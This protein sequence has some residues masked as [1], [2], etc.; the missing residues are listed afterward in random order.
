MRTR[1]K[2][3]T[4]LCAVVMTFGVCLSAYADVV[5]YENGSQGIVVGTKSESGTFQVANSMFTLGNTSGA[6]VTVTLPNG[7]TLIINNGDAKGIG[8]KNPTGTCTYSYDKKKHTLVITEGAAAAT[9][10][11]KNANAK[12][13]KPSGKSPAKASDVALVAQYAV[14]LGWQIGTSNNGDMALLSPTAVNA[15][16]IEFP[17]AGSKGGW[18]NGTSYYVNEAFSDI[19]LDASIDSLVKFID[20]HTK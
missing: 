17:S 6:A 2:V 18:A 8:T 5:T 11:A 3:L 19:E 13:Q 10:P 9:T 20:K 12:I 16:M 4:V 7:S 15:V 1:K 14:S